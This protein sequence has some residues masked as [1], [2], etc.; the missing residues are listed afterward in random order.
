[1]LAL[2][3]VLDALVACWEWFVPFV[4]LRSYE[5]GI[6]MYLGN[7]HKDIDSTTGVKGTGFH[8]LIPPLGIKT[9][10]RCNVVT[11][12]EVLDPQPLTTADAIAIT[13]QATLTYHVKDIRKLLLET[14]DREKAL[15]DTAAGIIAEQVAKHTWDQVRDEAFRATV[16]H[17][18]RK[19]GFRYGIEV[20][21]VQFPGLQKTRSL[22]LL[23]PHKRTQ[24]P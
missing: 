2:D 1:M 15:H 10:M 24:L 20:D 16:Y 18:V 3:R 6:I 9:C 7:P 5:R 23:Q 11:D 13:I 12:V 17:A 19:R 4:V 8:W 21:E 14:E 22:T